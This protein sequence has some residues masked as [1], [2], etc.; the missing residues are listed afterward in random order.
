MQ[1]KDLVKQGGLDPLDT[2]LIILHEVAPN[3][4]RSFLVTHDEL[5]VSTEQLE[6]IEYALAQRRAGVPLAY[7]LGK[8]E[9]Y[10]RDFVVDKDVLVPRPETES[11]IDLVKEL[12]PNMIVEVGTG[13]GCIAITLA[14][15]LPRAK[16]VAADISPAAL[17]IA[18]KNAKKLGAKVE[19][20]ESNLL[21]N[22]QTTADVVVANLP[23]VDKD[24]DWLEPGTLKYEP[25]LALYAEDGGLALIKRLI[26]Q[27]SELK[28]AKFLVLE[29]DPSQHTEIIKYAE[30]KTWHL[31]KTRGFGLTLSLQWSRLLE[32]D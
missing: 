19:L 1:I 5:T 10:G 11:L 12:Q 7:I 9:F 26:D 29:A 21:S 3:K 8:K 15:E 18:A 4:D 20:I 2:Q 32:L 13:S 24:W 28:M 22:V 23:Y 6:N 14:L 31:L 16:V 25:A 30:Q 17:N 27:V